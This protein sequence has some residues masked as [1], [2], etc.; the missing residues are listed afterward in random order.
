MSF[1]TGP[2]LSN[3]FHDHL[4]VTMSLKGTTV[5]HSTAVVSAPAAQEDHREL[6]KKSMPR[7]SP[8]PTESE[9]GGEVGAL[10]F[11][12]ASWVMLMNKEGEQSLLY[13]MEMFF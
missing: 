13:I 3:W 8:R 12:K 4:T 5:G 10:V 9:A 7:A 1:H 6:C 11:V 2:N